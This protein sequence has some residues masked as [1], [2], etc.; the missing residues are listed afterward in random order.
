MADNFTWFY[1]IVVIL[2]GISIYMTSPII[3][4]LFS[5]TEQLRDLVELRD[6]DDDRYYKEEAGKIL[7]PQSC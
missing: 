3:I 5:T 2:I 4:R 1:V 6:F 7:L